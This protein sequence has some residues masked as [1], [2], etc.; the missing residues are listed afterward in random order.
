MRILYIEDNATLRNLF[1]AATH[2]HIDGCAVEAV[3]TGEEALQRLEE[4]RFD[5]VVT[6]LQLPG[7]SGL[8]VLR[9]CR[10]RYP[11]LEIM[12]LTGHGS[13]GSAVEAMRLGARDYLEKPLDIGLMT[14]KLQRVQTLLEQRKELQDAQEA[15]DA[16]ERQAGRDAHLLEARLQD[17]KD[18]IHHVL[19]RVSG[20]QVSENDLEHAR[21]LLRQFLNR[22]EQGD[23]GGV[24]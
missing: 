24:T 8:E 22:L 19:Q 23:A 1:I 14:E 4:K 6:D 2:E 3:E 11:G 16:V 12:V 10:K 17:A 21:E 13:V 20:E 9:T 7:Q 18:T 15:K 5:L